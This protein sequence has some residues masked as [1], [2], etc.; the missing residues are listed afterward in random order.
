MGVVAADADALVV[1]L[2]GGAGGPGVLVAEG[3]VVVDEVADRL[4][5][6]PARR[7]A[8]PKSRQASA[9]RRSVSQ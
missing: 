8:V 1:G 7:G 9:V 3:D 2:G 4:D 5:P 6:G